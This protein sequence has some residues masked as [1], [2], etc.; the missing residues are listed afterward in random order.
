MLLNPNPDRSSGARLGRA[1]STLSL[2]SPRPSSGPGL[3]MD[4]YKLF[5]ARYLFIFPLFLTIY[6]VDL[7]QPLK[8]SPLDGALS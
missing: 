3:Q 2:S 8:L 4:N 1:D 5:L 7:S 6:L